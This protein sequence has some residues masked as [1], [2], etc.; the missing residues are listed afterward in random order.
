MELNGQTPPLD[1]PLDDDDKEPRREAVLDEVDDAG[2][3]T[4]NMD[5]GDEWLASPLGDMV[6]GDDEPAVPLARIPSELQRNGRNDEQSFCCC[7]CTVRFGGGRI[8]SW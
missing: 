7:F 4:V 1:E 5:D 3:Q 2:Q 6:R 8:H